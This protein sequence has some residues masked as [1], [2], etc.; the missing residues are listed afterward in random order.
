M[1]SPYRPRN[2]VSIREEMALLIDPRKV[3]G[4]WGEGGNV[5]DLLFYFFI[6]VTMLQ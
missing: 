3:T 4:R 2:T 5:P 6:Y 1:R